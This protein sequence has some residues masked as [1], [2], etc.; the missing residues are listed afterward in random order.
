MIVN[1][2]ASS[3][4]PGRVS[5]LA[6]EA[7]SIHGISPRDASNAQIGELGARRGPGAVGS[8]RGPAAA[9]AARASLTPPCRPPVTSKAPRATRSITRAPPPAPSPTARRVLCPPQ[10]GLRRSTPMAR[11]APAP[12]PRPAPANPA[13]RAPTTQR[14]GVRP[15]LPSY[16]VV[17]WSLAQAATSAWVANQIPPLAL[18]CSIR[19]SRIQTRER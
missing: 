10:A 16:E 18:A 12:R 3:R 4:V 19:A 5:S 7:I 17:A 15:R 1:S 13:T 11:P 14:P 2:H 9:G 6:L 8:G